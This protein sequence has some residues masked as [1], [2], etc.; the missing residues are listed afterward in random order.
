MG[1]KL[2]YLSC[3]AVSQISNLTVSSLT[4]KVWE[5]KAAPIVDSYE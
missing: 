1:A 3:P 4:A 2:W 5:K